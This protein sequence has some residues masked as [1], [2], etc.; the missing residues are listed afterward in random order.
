MKHARCEVICFTYLFCR[1]LVMFSV[2]QTVLDTG[3]IEVEEP[4]PLSSTGFTV[5]GKMHKINNYDQMQ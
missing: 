1:Y 4:C 3:D 2:H 5:M